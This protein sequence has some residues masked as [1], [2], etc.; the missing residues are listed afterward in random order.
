MHST[1]KRKLFIWPRV[2]EMSRRVTQKKWFLTGVVK[3]TIRRNQ[4][5]S[6]ERVSQ[7]KE[8]KNRVQT[9]DFLMGHKKFQLG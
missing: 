9:E 1:V 4:P 7:K 2:L 6:S 5:D 8:S 3:A